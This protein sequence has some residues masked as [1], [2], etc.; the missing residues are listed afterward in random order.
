MAIDQMVLGE[1]ES[2]EELQEYMEEYSNDWYMGNDTDSE[3]ERS[4]LAGK[5]NLFSMS[6]TVSSVSKSG[7]K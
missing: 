3:W 5:P 2:L 7:F 6:H 4:I 1:V